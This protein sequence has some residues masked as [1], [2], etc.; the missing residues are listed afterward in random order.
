MDVQSDIGRQIVFVDSGVPD[1]A[2]L[3]AGATPGE[4]VFVLDPSS[5]GLQQIADI[6]TANGLTGLASISIVGHGASGAIDLGSTV[7][8][9]ANLAS[10]AAALSSIGAALAPGGDLALYACDTAAGAAGAQF[11]SDL[12]AYAGG[13]DVAA[14]THLV[15]SADQ[16]GSPGGSW[17]LDAA[18]AAPVPAASVPFT[19]AA[20]SSFQGELSSSIDGQIWLGIGSTSPTE[21]PFGYINP[22]G[23]SPIIVDNSSGPNDDFLAQLSLDT[24]DGLYFGLDNGV[25]KSAAVEDLVSGGM[26]AGFEDTAFNLGAINGANAIAVDPANHVIYV[27]VWGTSE[28][29]SDTNSGIVKVSY[30]P[31]TG[32]INNGTNIA[33]SAGVLTS[34]FIAFDHS[35]NYFVNPLSFALDAATQKLYFVANDSVPGGLAG[36][37]F[38]AVNGIYVLTLGS[39]PLATELSVQTQFKTNSLSLQ[40]VALAL[41]EAQGLIYFVAE[42]YQ[43]VSST[44]PSSPT[45]WE[46]PIAGGTATQMTMPAGA[47]PSGVAPGGLAFDPATRQ[48]IVSDV[49]STSIYTL[50]LNAAGTAITGGSLFATTGGTGTVGLAFDSLPTIGTLS[51]TTSEAL[52]GGSGITLLAATPTGITDPDSGGFLA[53]VTVTISNPQAG[54][55]LGLGSTFSYT[56]TP[57]SVSVGG[58]SFVVSFNSATDTLT[59]ANPTNGQNHITVEN[60]FAQY[61]AILAE[62]SYEDTGTDATTV[63]HPIRTITWQ[64][65]D[66]ASGNPVGTTNVTTTTVTIDRAPVANPDTASAVSGGT[67]ATGNVVTN[68][69][70]KDGDTPTVTGFTDGSS[71]TLG[72]VFHGTYGDLTLNQNGSYTYSAGATAAEATAIA[73]AGSHPT[74]VVTYTESDGNGGTSSS[75]LT[76]TINRL[77]TTGSDSVDFNNLTADQ[78]AAIVDGGNIYDG[79]G[80]SDV[81]VLPNQADYNESVGS[82]HTLGWTN[83]SASTFYTSSQVGDDYTVSGG[84]GN[85]DIVEGAGTEVVTISGGGSS[86]VQLGSGSDSLTISGGGTLVAS[87]TTASG[88]AQIDDT[89]TLEFTSTY[90][91]VA[92]FSGAPTGSGGTLKLDVPSTGP[93]TVVNPNDTVIAQPGGNN[94]INAAVSYTLPGNID[95]LFL[96]AGARGTGNSDASGDALYALDAGN[97]QTLTGNSPNDTFVVDNTSDVVVPKAGS[98]D[99][100]YAAASFTLPTGVD[101]LI[102]EGGATQG[103]GNSDAAGDGLFAANPG[104]VATLTGNSPNDTFVVYNSSD[105]VV[106]KAGSHDVVYS[107]VSYTLPTGVDILILEGTA[108]QGVGN[109]DAAG[110]ALYAANAGIV[111][112]LTGN[113]ANDT[114]VV[115]NSGDVVVP[116]VGSHDIVYSAVNY[117]LPTGVDSL[118]LESGTQ[119][120]GNSDAAGDTL[121]AANAGIA[122]TLTGHSHNDSFVVYNSADVLIG[123]AGSTDTVYA[124]ASFTLPTNV[125]TLFLEGSASHGTGNGDTNNL[126]YGNAGVASTLVAGGGADTLYVTGTAGTIMTGGAGHDTFAFP[127]VMG[128]DEVTNFGLAK[129]TLQFNAT[130]FSNFTAAMNAA[131]QSGANTVFTIDANDTVTLDNVTKGSLTASNFHFT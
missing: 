8:D 124:A 3:I 89:S 101:T 2:A 108:S 11:I 109:S 100:V 90:V 43:N 45:L 37:A 39:S 24:V 87:G 32:V 18:T 47:T 81:V 66:G 95:A 88:T 72:S 77:F 96:Y 4:L 86:T 17:T 128:K 33:D 80:G 129:D 111:Q 102:L 23:G 63:G 46:M 57:T 97:A 105:V 92:T 84:D 30:N 65:N 19:A 21:N 34:Y 60:T 31:T 61:E 10:H 6:L 125:D 99:V 116:K 48:I 41:N 58:G 112:T 106:P 74:E 130:L 115:Y 14:A 68:D 120:V 122:Q 83:T 123:Q 59:I 36:T 104:Q 64:V 117:T 28:S 119:A 12:S 71:G 85:Y 127:N 94:W 76:V 26:S 1:L 35:G 121:Y 52:Q 114:F 16:G 20:L 15:G 54:D 110:D 40:L 53:S 75:T 70:D 98:H 38:L 62:V 51:G 27:G 73:N 107:A 49:N 126:L 5:D 9:D 13:V 78:Q 55:L 93:I 42:N 25:T 79:L 91:G 82:A 50:A 69:T 131:S 113:S 7:V 103:V 29:G 118:I 56:T 44:P 67:A 22:A